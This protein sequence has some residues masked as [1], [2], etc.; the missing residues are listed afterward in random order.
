VAKEALRRF[1]AI[2][3]IEARIRGLTAAE[4]QTKPILEAFKTWLLQ[5]LE[6]ESVLAHVFPYCDTGLDYPVDKPPTAR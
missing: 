3:K 6:E 5:R 4:T 2:Y 1:R